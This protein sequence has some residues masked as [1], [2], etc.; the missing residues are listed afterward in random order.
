[1]IERTLTKKLR[2]LSKKYPVIALTGPRQSGK[3][4]LVRHVFS[5]YAY[6]NLE[7][8]DHK[9][10]LE[11]DPRGI[12]EQYKTGGVVI[13]EAQKVPQ[14]FSYLQGIV[15]L[16]GK[17]GR[18]ILTG[19]QNFLLLEKI[20]QSLAGR[21]ALMTLFPFDLKELAGTVFEKGHLYD[22]LFY[23]SYPPLYDRKIEPADFYP[24]Y[25]QTYI[26]RD[27]R[28][29]TNVKNLSTFQRFLKLCA[30][31]NGQLLNYA[32]L[33]NDCGIDQKTA[34]AW[35]SIL[36]ASYIIYLLQPH[37][38]N[39]NKRLVKQPKLY[40]YDTGLLC[41]LLGIEK[42][43]QIETHYSKGA[44][45][46]ACVIS[47]HIKA[48]RHSAL[49][50]NAYFWRDNIGHEIDLIVEKA[51]ARIAVEIK[52]GATVNESFFKNLDFYHR[53]SN[54]DLKNNFL[55]YSGNEI[56]KRK[57]ARILPWNKFPGHF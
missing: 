38:E 26:E 55:V 6:L 49:Q 51:S 45:F 50:P 31:R 10:A 14:L 42:S 2:E 29:I 4:T 30:G 1:M 32:S 33:A 56:Q 22:Y 20:T 41:S 43:G 47:E 21:V 23:G 53:I 27:V 7:N 8:I 52:S 24:L 18:F 16:S 15:D 9:T 3:T 46:E 19:S 17:M 13:D 54:N 36:E 39:F 5:G 11:E 12:L 37:H 40:F 34:K 48:R 44:I 35:I 28:T 25:T 57:T